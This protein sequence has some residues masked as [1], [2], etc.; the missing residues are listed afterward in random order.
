MSF[1]VQGLTRAPLLETMETGYVGYD[2]RIAPQRI[3]DRDSTGA[4]N[5][6]PDK[7]E[8]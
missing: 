4:L 1:R 8:R 5:T 6:G 3:G 7:R 2:A